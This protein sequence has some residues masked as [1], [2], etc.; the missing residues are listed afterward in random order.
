MI[1]LYLCFNL[2]I[3]IFLFKTDVKIDSIDPAFLYNML[4][5]KESHF[6][7]NKYYTV[8][9]FPQITED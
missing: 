7:K 8:I 6:L 1:F 3:F 4:S 2:A 5:F 9:R